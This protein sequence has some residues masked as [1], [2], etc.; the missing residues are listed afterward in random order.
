MPKIVSIS[1]SFKDEFLPVFKQTA[2]ANMRVCQ[3]FVCQILIELIG[4]IR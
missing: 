3:I 2:F 1:V 4:A